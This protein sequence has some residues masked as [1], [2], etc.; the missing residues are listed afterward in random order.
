M[1]PIVGFHW[2]GI[3]TLVTLR[4]SYSR[5]L[6]RIPVQARRDWKAA[7]REKDARLAN[8]GATECDTL[9]LSPESRAGLRASSGR[10][11]ALSR[12]RLLS[13]DASSR[14]SA[15]AA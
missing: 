10:A 11:R 7:H 15:R 14:P 1:S 3:Q 12:R 8:D 5:E 13:V 2:C 9:A 6:A 4:R